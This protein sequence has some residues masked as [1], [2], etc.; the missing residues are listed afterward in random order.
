MDRSII[1]GIWHDIRELCRSFSSF[2]VRFVKQEANSLADRC[3]REVSG[4]TP[5]LYWSDCIPPA[6]SLGLSATSQQYF[7]LRTNQPPATSRNQPA[8]MFSQNKP[9]PATSQPNRLHNGYRMQQPMIVTLAL[10]E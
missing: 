7:S 4:S 1:A 9:A 8:V 2:S 10:F 5:E 3:V 6:C